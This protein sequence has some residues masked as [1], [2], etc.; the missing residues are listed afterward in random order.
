MPHSVDRAYEQVAAMLAEADR[1]LEVP[2]QLLG[3]LGWDT[4]PGVSD[5]GLAAVDLSGLHDKV[6][7]LTKARG[8]GT[9]EEIAAA[10]A[11]LAIGVADALDQLRRVAAGFSATPDYLART[12]IADEFFRRLLDFIVIQAIARFAPAVFAVG[13]LGGIFLG[14]PHPADPAN[15]QTEHL[16]HVVRWDRIG[17]LLHDPA[18]LLRDVYGWGTPDFDPSALIVNIGGLLQHASVSAGMR[19]LPARAETQVTGLPVPDGAE[20]TLQ[21]LISLVKGLGFEDLDVGIS[22]F[23]LR[24]TADGA[25]DGGMG[26]TPYARGTSDIS[27]P[28]ADRVAFTVD[29]TIDIEGGVALVLRPG[30]SPVLTTGLDTVAPSSTAPGSI[31]LAIR[32]EGG[33]DQ[34]MTLLDLPN[35]VRV[36]AKALSAGA[37]VKDGRPTVR[38]GLEGGHIVLD[39]SGGDGFLT[40]VLGSARV[41]SSFDLDASYA[42]GTG[43]QLGGSGG[44][45]L[46]IPVHVELGPVEIDNLYAAVGL[47]GGVRLELSAGF[48]ASLGPIQAVVD[49]MGV[50]A[51]VTFPDGGGN[52]GPADLTFGF[53]PPTGVGLTVNAGIVA[54]GGFLS[55]DPDRGEYAGAL[56]LEFAGFVA[57]K[58]IGL[59]S[60]RNPDFGGYSLLIVMTAEFGE[61]GIQLGYGFT[62]L[63]VGGLLGLNRGMNLQALVEGVRSGAVESVMFPEDVVANAPRILSDL[64]AFFPPEQGTFLIGPMA[65]IGWG[66]PTLISIE[67]GVI[68]EIPGNLAVLGVLRALLPNRDA[69]LLALQADFVGAVEFDKDRVWFFAR[70]FDSRVLTVPLTGE[71]GLLFAWGDNP[72][73]VIT[74]GGFHP[75]YKPPPLPF[76]MPNRVSV[77][78]LNRPNQLIRVSGYFAITSNTAQ[79][80]ALAE[81]RLGFSHFSI[82]GHLG[83]DALFQFSPFQFVINIS[84][85]VSLK[86]FGHGLFGIHLRFQLEGPAPYRA[87]GRGS[88]GFLFFE[89]SANFD[90]TWGEARDTTLPPIDVLPLLAAEIDKVEGWQTRLPTGR[91]TLVNLR[92]LPPGDDLVLHPLGTLFVRQRALPLDVRLDRIG[93]RQARDGRRFGVVPAPDS[94]LAQVSVTADK[95]AMAQYQDLDD[96]AKLSRPAYENQDAGLELA[97]ADGLLAS[98]RV[99]RRSARYEEIVIDSRARAAANRT[100]GRAVMTGA[101]ATRAAANGAAANGATA[102]APRKLTSVSP[103]VFGRLLDGSSTSRSVLSQKDAD[104]RRPFTGAD[105]VRLSGQ[106]F[107]VAY[108]RNNVQAFPPSADLA[109]GVAATFRSQAAAADA[110]A[111]WVTAVPSLAGTLHVIPAADASAPLAVPGTWTVGG[112]LP[113][114]T[115]WATPADPAVRLAG[116]RLLVA[117]GADGDGHP[118]TSVALF[119]PV[120]NTWSAGPD[121]STGR[122]Q[123]TTTLLADGRVLVAGGS[124]GAPLTSA[125]IYDP[126]TNA[127][128][129]A[130]ELGAARSGHSATLLGD[131]SVLVAGG[132]G[133]DGRALTSAERFDPAT[134]GWTTFA[135]MTDARSAHQAVRLRDGRVLVIGGILPTGGGPTA[136]A[137]CELFDPVTGGWTPTAELSTPRAGHQ[138]T[139]LPDGTVLVTGGDTAGVQADGAFRP[140]SLD[141]AETYDPAIGGWTPVA[142]MPGRRTRHRSVLLRTGRV[143]V[144][145][146]TGGPEFAAG[147]R[148]AAVYDPGS[149]TWTTTG[150]LALG[151]WAQ[152][153]AELADGRIVAAGGIARAGAAASGPGPAL[154][155]TTEIF[156]P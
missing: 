134:G 34:P 44:L 23:G 63:A 15:F 35:A 117:G 128:S 40:S 113:T 5:I 78:L 64:R 67:L 111:D 31:V 156:T 152:L 145:G 92:S 4:P 118:V 151:R 136:T 29:S 14:E 41:E 98:A 55:A 58:A 119:D 132:R 47:N 60:T 81:L 11:N 89:I 71:M 96:A 155:A 19:P 21:L 142:R 139:L 42:P 77:D 147:Y 133:P 20:P 154:S 125:E 84:A 53:K 49:R 8:S 1:H 54:G 114:A 69:A 6:D 37:G 26:I 16:R 74:V 12:H 83:F 146:G 137:Y 120:A 43:L 105:T 102:T 59:I 28:L 149:D 38:L 46:Q 48:S 10:Y 51:D 93:G 24:P 138:A 131:D 66:T 110:L 112:A 72:D 90:I 86:A 25:P 106:R 85:G 68:V 103:A 123:H 99:V 144:V 115:F 65:K 9:T 124:A 18:A 30:Q 45:E 150:A 7:A 61:T 143:L 80:G 13:Q 141:T 62:L 109:S 91:A 104:R 73:L 95:F 56:E 79:F 27:F 39:A 135:P 127:W 52:L 153:T 100:I 2:R 70:L 140:D 36:E 130:A 75:S 22:L 101:A 57:V 148:S 17:T 3:L 87:H 107:V 121:L 129:A 88:I 50:R 97:G 126:L 76:P 94:G 82:E 108:V 116:G 32:V 122:Q 33:S